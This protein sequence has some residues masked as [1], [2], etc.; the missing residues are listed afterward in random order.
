MCY[1]C[2]INI[3][4]CVNE[5]TKLRLFKYGEIH[6]YGLSVKNVSG[7]R[8]DDDRVPFKT[9]NTCD[10]SKLCMVDVNGLHTIFS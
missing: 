5:I 7:S 1:V 4:E 3:P 8:G 6:W 10:P 2:E 9:A